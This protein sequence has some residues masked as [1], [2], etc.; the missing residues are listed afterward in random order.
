MNNNISIAKKQKNI[1]IILVSSL[2]GLA[3]GS[4]NVLYRYILNITEKFSLS[5]YNFVA[6][7]LIYLPLLFAF[8]ILLGFII[9]FI[10]SHHKLIKGSGIPQVQGSIQGYITIPWY[11]T[12]IN[13][14]ISG[15]L[16]ILGGLSLGRG[17]PCVQFGA[18]VADGISEKVPTDKTEKRIYIASGASAGLASA[19]NTPLTGVIFVIE[20]IFKYIS[21]M[22]LLSTMI[23]AVVADYIS[24]VAFGLEPLLDFSAITYISLK[25]YWL[26][27]LL[28]FILGVLGV[29]YNYCLLKTQKLYAKLTFIKP[30]YRPIIPL[31]LA[32]ILGLTFPILLFSGYDIILQLNVTN[33]LIYLTF[34]FIVKFCFSM[35]SFGS[36]AP[37]G[38]FFPILVLGATI[39][40]IFSNI[41]ISFLNL[42]P[43]LF[44]NFVILAMAGYFVAVIRAPLTG[45]VWILEMTGSF[46]WLLPLIIT[47]AVSYVVAEELKSTPIGASL[48]ENLL[49]DLGMAQSHDGNSK[50]LIEAIVHFDSIIDGKELKNLDLPNKCLVISIKRGEDEITP[51][52]STVINAGDYL[53]VITDIS[54]QRNVRKSLEA[55][56]FT[57]V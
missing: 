18:C 3:T 49:G 38:I 7:N 46:S 48:L 30:I 57:E 10:S 51:N 5:L 28:G 6:E 2:I 27:I 25:Y 35:L 52:G 15:V 1:K 45:V 9:G 4:I 36:G 16:G 8:L 42:D 14:F 37:G 21:P 13:K 24:K 29:F 43:S 34:I 54:N 26:F 40:A 47:S 31:I 41:A 53:T 44:Y 39:G 19:F 20:Q 33:S 22:I 23:S 55:Q 32:G 56:V 12:L 17:G 11:D 50:I